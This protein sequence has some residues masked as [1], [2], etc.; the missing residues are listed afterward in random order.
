MPVNHARHGVLLK[1]IREVRAYTVGKQRRIMHQHR[2]ILPMQPRRLVQ[3]HAQPHQLPAEYLFILFSQRLLG[4]WEHPSARA[5]ENMPVQRQRIV[6]EGEHPFRQRGAQLAKRAP[7]VV[8]VAAQ[9]KFSPRQGRNGAQVVQGLVQL[10]GPADVARNKDYVP[11]RHHAPPVIADGF[12]MA[13]PM[14]A[15][16]VHGLLR[17]ARQVEIANGKNRHSSLASSGMVSPR[18]PRR[19]PLRFPRP[20]LRF[21]A[22]ARFRCRQTHFR[23]CPHESGG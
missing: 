20:R 4:G 23:E 7:P 21:P 22:K 19:R 10:H 9:Q 18:H 8:M 1:N 11:G 5:A 14:A 12:K 17:M 13:I 15:E 2:Q 16:N 6:L 3:R